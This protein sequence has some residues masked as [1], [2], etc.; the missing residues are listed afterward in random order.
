MQFM[1]SNDEGKRKR[2][3]E[4]AED[5]EEQH[6]PS[7]FQEVMNARV[8]AREARSNKSDEPQWNVQDDDEEDDEG[9][10]QDQKYGVKNDY[11]K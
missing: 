7:S 5:Q 10:E 11:Q 8:Q 9:D 2:A 3:V 6:Q 1:E 4:R